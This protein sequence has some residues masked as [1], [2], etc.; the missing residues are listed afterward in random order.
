[1]GGYR[2]NNG[3]S[4]SNLG[5]NGN[6]WS[7]TPNSSNA[8]WMRNL[9]YSKTTVYRNNYERSNGF[10]VRCVRN[11]TNILFRQKLFFDIKQE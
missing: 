3:S 4:F 6:W 9:N 5:T 7:S 1:M 11:W 8:A 10:S 2:V